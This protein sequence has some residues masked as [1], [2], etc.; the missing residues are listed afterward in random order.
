ML[1]ILLNGSDK[2]VFLDPSVLY[3]FRN[4]FSQTFLSNTLCGWII[5]QHDFSRAEQSFVKI[6]AL[7]MPS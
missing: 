2:I 5:K 7:R 3:T 6:L 4:R 1:P